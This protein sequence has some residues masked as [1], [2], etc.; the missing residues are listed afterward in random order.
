VKSEK[1]FLHFL[2]FENIKKYLDF[3]FFNVQKID[4]SSG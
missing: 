2:L 1:K 4:G 3:E